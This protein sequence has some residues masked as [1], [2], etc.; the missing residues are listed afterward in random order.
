M[1]A[2]ELNKLRDLPGLIARGKRRIEELE[3]KLQPGGTSMDGMPHGTSRKNMI[4]ELVPVIADL[5]EQVRKYEVEQKAIE[6]YINSVEDYHVR[7]ILLH[8]F[9]DGLEWNEVAARVGGCNTED[10]VRK[11]CNRFLEKSKKV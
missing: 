3:A 6:E 4:E 1:T 2:R 7:S 9:V 5:R 8:R 11:A 10:S